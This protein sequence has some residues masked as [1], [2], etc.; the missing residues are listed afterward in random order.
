MA[1][2]TIRISDI[3]RSLYYRLGSLSISAK[4][5]ARNTLALD[6]IDS[7]NELT[8]STGEAV[9]AIYLGEVI[10]AGSIDS[11]RE[12]FPSF[13][14]NE[15][16][17]FIRLSCVDYTQFAD[18]RIVTAHYVEQ[19]AGD[20]VKNLV[21]KYLSYDG[22]TKFGIEDGLEIGP[23]TFEFKSISSALDK[24]AELIGYDWYIDYDKDLKFFAR[25][26]FDAP[27]DLLDT[28]P[29]NYREL[30]C[31]RS[32]RGYRN[33]QVVRGG[34]DIGS[35]RIRTFRGDGEQSTFD[36]ELP[37]AK[38]PRVTVNG[39]P[40]S[41][42]VR[43]V[44]KENEEGGFQWFWKKNDEA[45]SQ[46]RQHD[47]LTTGDVMRVDFEPFL[48][49]VALVSDPEAI[50]ERQAVEGGLGIHEAVE[51]ETD[52]ESAELA[53]NFA[54]SFLRRHARIN[55]ELKVQTLNTGLKPGQLQNVILASEDLND[56]YLIT[57]VS[58][59]DNGGDVLVT[60]YE[61][62]DNENTGG[63]PE[64]FKKLARQGTRF[65]IA[66]DA[67]IT[68]ISQITSKVKID[69]TDTSFTGIGA[70]LRHLLQD[71]YSIF[72]IDFA[73]IG[74]EWVDVG[75]EILYRTGTRIGEPTHKFIAFTDTLHIFF[76]PHANFSVDV[77]I[78]PIVRVALQVDANF[79]IGDV[80][81]GTDLSP[82]ALPGSSY[83]FE[84]K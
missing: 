73:A 32:R 4:L 5:G 20:I 52:I 27:F 8:F 70:R 2:F 65:E 54:L 43:G 40:Q 55:C 61:A 33:R 7:Q 35:T 82:L 34:K 78:D 23:L 38:Q 75:T 56:L 19:L 29:R 46:N 31:E 13:D 64:F 63:W 17:K 42:G 16:T 49:I 71:P 68:P 28:D 26:T 10:F 58:M 36:V 47:K 22:V 74:R 48:P 15:T 14:I 83:R 53:S 24:I 76:T 69:A 39:F 66:A 18:K 79:I 62:I 51:D 81:A 84:P 30:F 9:E 72:L 25:E 6:L 50:D 41:I 60:S 21:D 3:D 67:T 57:S 59:R 1:G 11:V 37:V 45:I 12:V 77:S 44:D 80:L